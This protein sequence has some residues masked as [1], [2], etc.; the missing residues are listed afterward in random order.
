MKFL[1]KT[2]VIEW[3]GWDGGSE[4]DLGGLRKGSPGSGGKVKL[5]VNSLV[6]EWPGLKI[7][8]AV[9]HFNVQAQIGTRFGH[10]KG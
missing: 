6:I 8:K 5:V 3:L 9:L 1:V 2:L 10:R 7:L 4:A